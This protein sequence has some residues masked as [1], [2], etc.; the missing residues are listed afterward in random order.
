MT[1]HSD[2]TVED[3]DLDSALTVGDSE[4]DSDSSVNVS[5]IMQIYSA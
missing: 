5:N 1:L 2:L 3:L 4:L